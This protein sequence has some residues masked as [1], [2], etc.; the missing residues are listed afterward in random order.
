MDGRK[1]VGAIIGESKV[2]KKGQSSLG[3]TLP[4]L[5]VENF[6]IQKGDKVVFLKIHKSEL[7][8]LENYIDDCIV[9]MI[10]KEGN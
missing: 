3:I 1:M 10:E 6:N 9:L 5:V 4:K 2:N 7:K 8:E